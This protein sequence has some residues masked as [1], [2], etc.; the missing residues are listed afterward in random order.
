MANPKLRKKARKLVEQHKFGPASQCYQQ[1]LQQDSSDWESW[2]EFGRLHQRVGQPDQ[3][4][5]CFKRV[6]A[7]QPDHAE[8]FFHLGE[9]L[10]ALGNAA[11]ATQAYLHALRAR[12]DWLEAMLRLAKLSESQTHY[13]DALDWYERLLSLAPGHVQALI[14]QG[15]VFA[16]MGR[17]ARAIECFRRALQADPQQA[18]AHRL[19]CYT[20]YKAGRYQEALQ[21]YEAMARAFPDRPEPL[22]SRAR[23]L[24]LMGQKDEA[25]RQLAA[26]VERHPTNPFVALAYANLDHG[27]DEAGRR[28]ELLQ[29]I[30][31]DHRQRLDGE[32]KARIHFNLGRLLD[33]T[34]QFDQAF[35][36]Y[37]QGNQLMQRP[38]A[39][40]EHERQIGE[41]IRYHAPDV[42][43]AL[44]RVE[45][46]GR[47]NIFI[48]GMP[49]S[50]TTLTEQI[51]S[52]HHAIHGGGELRAISEIL[53]KIAA[54]LEGHPPYPE[55]MPRLSDEVCREM[56]RYYQ[57]QTAA[58]ARDDSYVTDKMPQNFLSLGLIARLLPEARIIHCQRDPRD[59]C[60]SC[61]F[62]NFSTGHAYANDLET[63]GRYYRQYRRLMRHW[64]DLLGERILT[65]KY[66]QLT[67]APED[68]IRRMLDF[69]GLGWDDNCLNFHNSRRI[70]NTASYNQVRQPLNRRS[71]ARWRRYEKHLQPLL[72]MFPEA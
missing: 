16:L 30:L 40:D 53:G 1:L 43:A 6:I 21:G 70:V 69:I 68:T 50:G 39:I 64:Y 47:R 58:L 24:D 71:V 31:A 11:D 65:V 57:E 10:Q 54:T 28:I 9:A 29:G 3:A 4:L 63:L 18:D 26:L 5:V 66:E 37:R 15:N 55:F 22:A 32:T 17:D 52:S 23:L 36:H 12:P 41:I 48:V 13:Q 59:T 34:H 45:G 14:G 2:L 62:Q 60:L 8:A 25:G 19:Y 44:P 46:A 20:L 33:Q 42:F 49:R 61:Y 27:R 67:E 56:S 7:L 51:L 35:A 38:F 72:E